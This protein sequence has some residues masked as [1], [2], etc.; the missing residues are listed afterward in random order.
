MLAHDAHQGFTIPA[1]MEIGKQL[2]QGREGPE[3]NPCRL[4]LLES[5]ELVKF[6]RNSRSA[7]F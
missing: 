3:R 2:G 6:M 1:A 5:N 7:R 4:P